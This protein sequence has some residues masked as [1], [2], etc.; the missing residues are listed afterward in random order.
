[1]DLKLTIKNDYFQT[2]LLKYIQKFHSL[3]ED[4]NGYWIIKGFI[5]IAKNIYAISFDT[6]VVSKILELVMFPVLKN[7]AKD[8]SFIMQFSSEQNCY[9]YNDK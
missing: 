8:N 3:L 2:N 1:M 5:D 7:F 4:S 6:K 9:F